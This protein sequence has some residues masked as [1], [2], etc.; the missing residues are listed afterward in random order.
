[1]F[2]DFL[3]IALMFFAIFWRTSLRRLR[4]VRILEQAMLLV[5][6]EIALTF[7]FCS[8]A[9]RPLAKEINPQR[10]AISGG[11]VD[12][13]NYGLSRWGVIYTFFI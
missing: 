9:T 13:F 2:V 7:D 11:Y 4:G 5:G 10:Y 12:P 1:M 3:A 6:Q 8:T